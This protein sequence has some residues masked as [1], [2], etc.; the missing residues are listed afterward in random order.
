M[1]DTK[2]VYPR[3]VN[4]DMQ[5][6]SNFTVTTVNYYSSGGHVTTYDLSHLIPEHDAASALLE[7]DLPHPAQTDTMI[8][9]LDGLTLSPATLD[10]N[11]STVVGD[12]EFIANNKIKLLWTTG[13]KKQSATDTPVLL[14]RYAKL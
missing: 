11:T 13:L 14:A 2:I 12:Y 7:F 1:A 8:L 9:T 5:T 10:P 3:L 6:G 4:V